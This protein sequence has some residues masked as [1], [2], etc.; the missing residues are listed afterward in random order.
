MLT[1]SSAYLPKNYPSHGA[2]VQL[3]RS[4][5][6]SQGGCHKLR[7]F[8][9]Q[10]SF[11]I[12]RQVATACQEQP[13]DSCLLAH[14]R[15]QLGN[16]VLREPSQ[17]AASWRQVSFNLAEIITHLCTEDRVSPRSPQRRV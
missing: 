6:L 16:L 17:G 4:S 9:P 8:V 7:V 5:H 2:P 13:S 1:A 15:K 12:S 14:L 11:Q 10:R 3:A